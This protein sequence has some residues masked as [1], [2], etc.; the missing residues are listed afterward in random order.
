MSAASDPGPPPRAR[1]AV[2]CARTCA[3]ATARSTSCRGQ[4]G[5]RAARA[6]QPDRAQRRRQVDRAEDDH[7]V[8]PPRDGRVPV[9]RPGR[10]RLGPRSH[11][12]PRPGLRAPGAR[13]VPADDRPGEPG[14]GRLHR[15]DGGPRAGDAGRVSTRS[16]P[17]WPSAASSVRGRCPGG[18]QQ[19]LAIGRALMIS[20]RA[21]LLDEPSLGLSPLFV[22]LI[23]DKIAELRAAG[24]DHC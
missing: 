12:A 8:P 10:H 21:L 13:R 18:E 4:P 17:A 6:G 20:P 2:I 14:D 24:N 22:D 1:P 3:P 9:R 16:F 23:F 19:M 15:R 7:G 5:S 11:R